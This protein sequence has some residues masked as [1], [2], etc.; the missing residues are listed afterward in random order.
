M[1]N[2]ERVLSG[3]NMTWQTDVYAQTMKPDGFLE[4]LR[5]GRIDDAGF[6]TLLAAVRAG[7][8]QW[9]DNLQVERFVVACLFEVPF[10][11]ENAAPRFA[12]C[13]ETQ[14]RRVTQM[15]EALRTAIHDLLWQGLEAY[16]QNALAESPVAEE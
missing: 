16:Y 11:V 12:E 4:C 15:A 5:L 6:N 10:E 1:P 13:S 9:T 3:A 8:R 14:G 2:R 7:A